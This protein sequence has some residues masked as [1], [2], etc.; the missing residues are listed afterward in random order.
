MSIEP[1]NSLMANRE[2][3]PLSCGVSGSQN[4]GPVLLLDKLN[5]VDIGIL[6]RADPSMLPLGIFFLLK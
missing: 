4:L 2:K 3:A 5:G 1:K 6:R